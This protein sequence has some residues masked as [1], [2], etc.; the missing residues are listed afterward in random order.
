M[1]ILITVTDRV[2]IELERTLAAMKEYKAN[3][4]KDCY[5]NIWHSAAKRASLDLS[6]KLS[7]WRKVHVAFRNVK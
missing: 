2:I 3:P 1:M 7:Q 5:Q 4:K 6:R